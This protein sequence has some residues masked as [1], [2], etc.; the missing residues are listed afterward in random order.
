MIH[1]SWPLLALLAV[2]AM[3]GCEDD[4]EPYCP[5]NFKM[6]DD[7]CVNVQV[8]SS[9]CGDGGAKCKVGETC[10][11]GACAAGC[12][13]GAVDCSGNCVDTKTDPKNCGKCGTTCKAGEVCSLGK[14]AASCLGS[15]SN[16]SG[17]CVDVK[18]D[19]KNCGKCDTK[20]KTGEVCSTGKCGV[21][22]VG[23]AT[24]CSGK[25]VDV[26]LDPANCGSCGNVCKAG[27]VCS[28]G[29][30]GLKCVGGTAECSGK[31]VDTQTSPIHCGKCGTVCPGKCVAG[32]CQCGDGAI[33]TGEWCDG[34]DLGGKSCASNGFSLGALACKQDCTLD[35][36]GCTWAVRFGGNKSD[37]DEAA[38]AV[39]AK[40]NTFIAAEFT[41]TVPFGTTTVVSRGDQDVFV[42]KL[43]PDGKP[44]WAVSAG[45]AKQDQGDFVAVDPQG[46]AHVLGNY[47][48][49]VDFGGK[50]L[51]V[52]TPL[53]QTSFIW[54]LSAKGKTVWASSVQGSEDNEGVGI[55]VDAAGNSYAV[56]HFEGKARFGN[57]VITSAGSGDGYVT[58]LDKNGNFLWALRLGGTDWDEAEA[59]AVDAAGNVYVS[60]QF[61]GSAT[62]GKTV[63]ASAS[64]SADAFVMKL[65]S[66][67]KVLWLRTGGSTSFDDAEAVGVDSAGNVY[68]SGEIEGNAN[69]GTTALTVAADQ[70][71]YVWKMD[72]DG[73]HIWAVQS[74]ADEEAST[75]TGVV[76]AQGNMYLCGYMTDKTAFGAAALPHMDDDDVFVAKIDKDGKWLWARAGSSPQD[77]N[78]YGL[79][80]GPK[81]RVHVSGDYEQ[82]LTVGAKTLVS[83]KHYSGRQ[84]EDLFV[85]TLPSK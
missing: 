73:K 14:C 26:Q 20:C 3:A 53:K 40:G 56:G 64:G 81:D 71:V 6:C 83:A 33:Q 55:A 9:N 21:T 30:C 38:L 8:D 76:D 68:V 67:G 80:L 32:K 79:A 18:L 48:Q 61:R 58:K 75:K 29:K 43:D 37:V 23:G 5:I 27:Q 45:S 16:C 54:K 25:C 66:A 22:C 52:Q 34:N 85:W 59:V 57:A 35:T 50:L 41:G 2:V 44:L 69:F 15:T 12:G 82:Y 74:K 49:S 62:F 17:K 19:P 46:N 70:D 10:V 31:C 24:K 60:G 11:A 1:K 47:R 28:A 65:D 51:I 77:A 63:S 78:C 84:D 4:P 72:K 36:A 39:D 42:G 7:S 13:G